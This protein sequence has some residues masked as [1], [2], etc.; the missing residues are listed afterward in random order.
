MIVGRSAIEEEIDVENLR[1][2]Q[3]RLCLSI[4]SFRVLVN[5]NLQSSVVMR[6]SWSKRSY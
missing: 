6:A 3:A 4:S 1:P 2:Q 5:R